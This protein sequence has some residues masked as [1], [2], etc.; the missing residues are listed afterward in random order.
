MDEAFFTWL[1]ALVGWLV[2]WLIDWL[3][4]GLFVGKARRKGVKIVDAERFTRMVRRIK[5]GIEIDVILL[6]AGLTSNY[7]K[8]WLY[9]KTVSFQYNKNI[10]LD[11]LQHEN[12]SCFQ[13]LGSQVECLSNL[14]LWTSSLHVI[15]FSHTSPQE[16]I[17]INGNIILIACNKTEK[18]SIFYL[19]SCALIIRQW[20]LRF[21]NRDIPNI[22]CS[23]EY[24]IIFSTFSIDIIFF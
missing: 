20:I 16:I 19:Y 10:D 12:Y 8:G 3:I 7:D 14:T 13:S 18:R 5:R 1:F 2:D 9:S 17:N 6:S 4:D 24:L 15:S 22:K 21:F 23:I 11:Y